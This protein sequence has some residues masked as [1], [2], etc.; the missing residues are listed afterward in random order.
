MDDTGAVD[1]PFP[2]AVAERFE[3]NPLVTP[4][5]DERI[6]EN[7]NGPS[8]VRAPPWID[9]P[10]GEYY[11]Y[12]AHH[13]G[14]Y[15][16][17]A[18]ADDPRGPWTVHT[19]GTLALEATQFDAHV[20]SP[21][22]HADRKHRRMRLYFHGC[23]GE[24]AVDGTTMPQVTDVALS[25]DG[26]AFEPRDAVLGNSYFRVFEHDGA[27]YALANDGR[28]YRADGE[29][30][31]GPFERGPVLFE[32]NRHFG[33]Q[34]VD[35]TT[36]RVFLTRRGD[37][38]ER[39]LATTLDLRPDWREWEPTPIPPETVL[40]PGRGY[41]GGDEPVHTSAGGP[42]DEPVRALRDPCVLADG[43]RTYL[44]YAIA[45]ERGIAGAE[46]RERAA[47]Q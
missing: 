4:G 12:F 6:G 36:V 25:T 17:L 31:L 41:E 21:D 43:D 38:P 9:D 19:P 5:S 42:V 33:V 39:T 47:E 45:G 37:R 1:T 3:T 14:E 30:P 16:R 2:G 15:V 44:Y 29:D 18:A 13:G 40:W 7:I 28:L 27:H 24:Y 22:V 26:L 10:L 8:V 20:A 46:L 35:P 32:R 11:M 34:R 23:C